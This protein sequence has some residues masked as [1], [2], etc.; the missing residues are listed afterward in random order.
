MSATGDGFKI[1]LTQ[2]L[3]GGVNAS[4]LRSALS[5]ESWTYRDA[6][7]YGSPE[8]DTR[9]EDTTSIAVSP[10]RKSLFVTLATTEQPKV[11]PR[12]TARIYHLKLASQTLF[13][14]AAP[15]QLDAYYTLKRFPAK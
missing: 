2:P 6:P 3:G 13:D 7:D 14:A 9:N 15:Q 1:T 8:L 12:Q 11:H 5:I 4:L 10:D